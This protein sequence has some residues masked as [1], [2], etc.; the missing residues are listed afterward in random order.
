MRSLLN[1]SLR[2]S[3]TSDLVL[4]QI[5]PDFRDIILDRRNKYVIDTFLK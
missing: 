4:D 3:I 2:Y 5:D 1:L